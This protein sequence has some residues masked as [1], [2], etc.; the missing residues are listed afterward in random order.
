LV[1]SEKDP[2]NAQPDL[3]DMLDLAERLYEQHQY[4]KVVAICKRLGEIG[5]SGGLVAVMREGCENALRRKAA[6]RYSVLLSMLGLLALGAILYP[7]LTRFR[8]TPPPAPIELREGQSQIFSVTRPFG[9]HRGYMYTWAV[10]TRDGE[11][12]QESAQAALSVTPEQPWLAQYRAHASTVRAVDGGEPALQQLTLHVEDTAGKEVLNA[13]WPLTVLDAPTAPTLAA[14]QPPANVPVTLAPDMSATFTANAVDGDGGTALDFAWLLN[15]RQVETRNA[16]SW[17]Y[18]FDPSA[19]KALTNRLRLRGAVVGEIACRVSNAHGQALPQTQTWV[20]RLVAA[21]SRPTLQAIEPA[22]EPFHR[23][24]EGERLELVAHALDS[25]VG[26]VLSYRW[27]IDGR[28]QSRKATC[29]L[30]FAHDSTATQKEVV[31]TLTVTDLCGA[32]AERTWPL[33]IVNAPR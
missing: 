10:L 8:V 14:A 30:L 17:T 2:E 21:N 22:I 9:R 5:H 26:D 29:T 24:A 18:K 7:P 27:A 4:R 16:P 20:L 32:T 3:G 28:P 12:L 23:V 19:D 25:D 15:G 31:L 13:Q 6:L 11:N 1:N 33:T